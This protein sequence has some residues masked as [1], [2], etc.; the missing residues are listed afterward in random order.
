MR[1]FRRIRCVNKN[2][3]F[4][5]INII[6]QLIYQYIHIECILILLNKIQHKV[7][8]SMKLNIRTSIRYNLFTIRWFKHKI[9]H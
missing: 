3:V 4:K 6:F 5:Q 2:T 1:S 7:F 9:K 8:D